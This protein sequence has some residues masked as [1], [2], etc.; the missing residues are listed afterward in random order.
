M[1]STIWTCS[2]A[3]AKIAAGR[4]GLNVSVAMDALLVPQLTMLGFRG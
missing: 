2:L 3:H 1:Y 4:P